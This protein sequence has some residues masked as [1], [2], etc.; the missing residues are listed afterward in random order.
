MKIA[1][2]DIVDR[3]TICKLK[4]ERGQID[5]S[6]EINDLVA[7]IEKYEDVQPYID[8]L[9]KLHSEI[10]DLEGDIRKGNEEILGLEEVGRRAIKLRDMNKIRIGIKN[11]INSKYNEGYIEI[12]VDHGS[13]QYPSV[14]ITLTTVPERLNDTNE[15]GIIGV[16]ES[17]C[18]QSD[19]DYEIHFNIPEIYNITGE[20]YV[21]PDWLHEYKLKYRNLKIFRTKDYGP[22]TKFVP[23]LDRVKDPETIMLV[24]DD[25]LVYHKDMISEHRKHQYQMMGLFTKFVICYAGTGCMIPLYRNINNLRDTWIACVTRPREADA[26][27]HYKSVSYKKKVFDDDFYKYYLGRTLSDD[28]LASK[29]WRD[30]GVKMIV[31]PYEP[32]NHLF[33]TNELWGQNLRV[34]TFPVLRNSSSVSNTGCNHPKLLEQPMGVRFFDPPNLGDR[35]W[36]NEKDPPQLMTWSAKRGYFYQS[37]MEPPLDLTREDLSNPIT[38]KTDIVEEPSTPVIEEL[39]TPVIEELSTPVIDEPSIQ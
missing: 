10:W 12:K 37:E 6:K 8:E 26:V 3:Y 33:A 17:L 28:A 30:K 31:V 5:N 2:G 18:T 11:K 14:I 36:E 32:E 4:S 16:I 38:E 35:S 1:I 20:K 21:I 22:P 27:Q 9:Y 29:Y 15:H 19:N 7:E 34:E 23:T 13:E 24:V 25:D 39:S